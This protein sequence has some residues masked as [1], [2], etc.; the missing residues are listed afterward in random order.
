MYSFR[1]E[2]LLRAFLCHKHCRIMQIIVGCDYRAGFQQTAYVDT[3][4]GELQERRIQQA[5]AGRLL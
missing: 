4:T 3:E 1:S 2:E 5:D